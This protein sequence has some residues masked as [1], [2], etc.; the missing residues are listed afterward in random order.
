[1]NINKW[2]SMKRDSTPNNYVFFAKAN[3]RSKKLS[4]MLSNNM[5]TVTTSYW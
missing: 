3:K 2:K 5:L 4:P 1:M